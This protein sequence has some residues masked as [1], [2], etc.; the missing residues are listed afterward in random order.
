LF[1]FNRLPFNKRTNHTENS[2]NLFKLRTSPF[3]LCLNK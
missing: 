3:W 1:V 2:P